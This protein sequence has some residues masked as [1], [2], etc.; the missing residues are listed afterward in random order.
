MHS[1]AQKRKQ[2][3]G[4]DG[5]KATGHGRI[6]VG[7]NS[8]TVGARRITMREHRNSRRTSFSRAELFPLNA[9][10][11]SSSVRLTRTATHRARAPPRGMRR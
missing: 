6:L 10:R 7:S 4:G 11:T 8:P 3:Q 9:K 2:L 5:V 1:G